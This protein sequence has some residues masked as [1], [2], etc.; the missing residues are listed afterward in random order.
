MWQVV[1]G[2]N[3][4]LGKYPWIGSGGDHI[5]PLDLVNLLMGQGFFFKLHKLVIH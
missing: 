5:L 3:I 2:R 4:R 1:N